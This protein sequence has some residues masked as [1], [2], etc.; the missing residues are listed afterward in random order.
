M[1]NAVLNEHIQVVTSLQELESKINAAAELIIE[2]MKRGGKIL[3]MGNGGSAADA[4]HIAAELVV[5]YE[6]NRVALPAI[7]LTTDSSILTATGN[8]FGFDQLFSRQVEA[9]ARKGDL[10]IG[11]STSGESVNIIRALKVAEEIGVDT[12][13]LT[14]ASG[15]SV[16]EI[17]TQNI[18]VPSSVTA[19]IQEAHI[20]IGHYWCQQVDTLPREQWA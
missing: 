3:L 1:F 16:A 18:A 4:Q 7:A 10:V 2:T 11:I 17:V 14:G 9:L 13:G 20:L 5:R 12:I 19:R 6:K 8:D 15:S